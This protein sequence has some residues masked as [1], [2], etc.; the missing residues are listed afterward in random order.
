MPEGNDYVIIDRCAGTG[1]LEAVF[2]D[3]ELSHCILST[4][5]Y[6][7]YKVLFERL[8]DKVR[9]IV[10]PTEQNIE[11]SSGLI[12]NADAMSKEFIDNEVIKRY[13][14]DPKVTVIMYENPP[15]RDDTAD[16]KGTKK[17]K[18]TETYIR[19]EMTEEFNGSAA[20]ARELSN[21]FIW[22]AFKYYMKKQKTRMS[23]FH[24]LNIGKR[25]YSFKEIH[26]R[27]YV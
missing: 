7:E 14:D 18:V 13:I 2:T 1:N 4:Y 15:Y 23:Y 12:V 5:E 3:E 16:N 9:H 6:F 25:T 8:G 27:I 20:T 11:F 22:S 24:Q 19:R 17:V 21:L 26:Q 10:P